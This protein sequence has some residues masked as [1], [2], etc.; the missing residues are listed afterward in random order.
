MLKLILDSIANQYEAQ[1]YLKTLYSALVT[2]AYYGL[3][4]IGEVSA[5]P[6]VLLAKNV[7]V[8]VNKNKILF[9]F[10]TS[11]THNEG[12]KPQ[13]VKITSSP[14]CNAGGIDQ[15]CTKYC[16]FHLLKQYIAKRPY[17]FADSE[18]FFIFKD[19]SPLSPSQVLKAFHQSLLKAGLQPHAYTFHCLHS[20]RASGLL[21][22]GLSV[23]TIK[24]VGRWRSNSV[25][26]Y[27]RD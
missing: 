1:V 17:S 6:H 21:H 23:E 15:S 24:K 2:S 14:S 22:L 26:T 18:Q 9:I 12:D 5:S 25:F 20:S 27:L 8:G 10:M 3:L 19:R 16:P 13:M 4:H 7:H 11:K